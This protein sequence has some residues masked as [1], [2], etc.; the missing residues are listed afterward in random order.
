MC[1]IVKYSLFDLGVQVLKSP[2][3]MLEL[4]LFLCKKYY[5][6][7][8]YSCLLDAK[9]PLS[10]GILGL[11]KGQMGQILSEKTILC[12]FLVEPNS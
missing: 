2:W 3:K 6:L 12:I 10:M 9:G 7:K 8:Q 11:Y 1:K 5:L 4:N